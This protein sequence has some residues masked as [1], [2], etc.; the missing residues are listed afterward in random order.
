M[1]ILFVVTAFYPEQAIGSVRVT[2][3]VKYLQKQ[4]DEITV[5]SL[6]PPQWAPR[7]ETL[8]FPGLKKIR[9]VQ[10]EQ[11]PLFRFIFLKARVAAVGDGSAAGIV[12]SNGKYLNFFK[13]VAQF[14]YTLFKAFDWVLQVRRYAKNNL[15]SERFDLIFTSYPSL[16]SPFSGLYL[17]KIGLSDSLLIDFRDPIVYEKHGLT[18]LKAMIQKE[19]F[20]SASLVTC[21]S[22][23]VRGMVMGARPSVE[24]SNKTMVLNNG[25]DPED[26]YSVDE[27]PCH[28]HGAFRIVYTGALYAGKRNI[29]PLLS[30]LS[31]LVK[32]KKISREDIELHYAG[33]E[34]ELFLRLVERWGLGASVINHGVLSR[35]QSLGLQKSANLCIL[36]TWNTRED[37]GILTGKVFEFFMLRKPVLCIVSGDLAN[38]EIKKV[39]GKVGAG[40]CYELASPGDFPA[41]LSWL[42][43]K[44]EGHIKFSVSEND[45]TDDVEFYS[46]EKIVESLK[47]KMILKL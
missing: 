9:W 13:G 18:R 21:A 44:I 47:K 14:C 25:F 16:A 7:D 1:K 33:H 28:E 42:T 41:M 11:S 20:S 40:F 22:N 12:K 26:V 3:F 32:S 6:T 39:I 45:Y 27:F 19:L 35:S 46:F 31:V 17:K 34:G 5:L 29:E 36:A 23:G 10:V 2:K 8:Y 4:G 15:C 38:S 30:A 43:Q 24:E 37:Q